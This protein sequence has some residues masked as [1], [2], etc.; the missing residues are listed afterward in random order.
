MPAGKKI[1]SFVS[2]HKH[3]FHRWSKMVSEWS[4]MNFTSHKRF[5][6][7]LPGA[8]VGKQHSRPQYLRVW[9]CAHLHAQ[10]SSGSRLGKQVMS[11][12]RELRH[13]ALSEYSIL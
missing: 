11:R 10:R 5:A 9:E 7:R 2:F 13:S 1:F 3:E 8:A 4:Q 12:T 6:R